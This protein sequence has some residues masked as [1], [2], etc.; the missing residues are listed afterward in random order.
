MS[1]WIIINNTVENFNI[2]VRIP[3]HIF[4][5]NDANKWQQ[6]VKKKKKHYFLL[7]M[8]FYLCV[9]LTL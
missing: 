2:T 8:N 7:N 9:L 5:I 6:F 4:K 1:I 3:K